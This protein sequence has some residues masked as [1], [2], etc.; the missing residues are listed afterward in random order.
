M[1]VWFEVGW[2]IVSVSQAPVHEVGASSWFGLLRSDQSD[3]RIGLGVPN[4][5]MIDSVSWITVNKFYN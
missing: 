3:I 1:C 2:E 4:Y 5:C